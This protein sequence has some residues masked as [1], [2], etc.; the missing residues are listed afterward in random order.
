[1][2]K[3]PLSKC[4]VDTEVEEAAL[5]A[6]R[7]GQCILGPECQAFEAE[8]AAAA[9]T[10]HGALTSSCTMALYLLHLAQGLRPGDEVIVPS[11]TAFPTI[12]P[13][14]HCGATPVFVDIDDTFC[15]DPAQIAAAITPRTVGLLRSTFTAIR[16]TWTP[17]R[18]SRLPIIFG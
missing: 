16:R 2:Q 10:P 15:L 14:L 5:R 13:L 9:G 4:F 6:L 7:S 17:S 8:L 11:H 12:E 3:I 18:P 1:M